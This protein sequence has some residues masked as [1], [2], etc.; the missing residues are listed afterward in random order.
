[1]VKAGNH[2]ELLRAGRWFRGLPEALQDQLSA[3]G[4]V[5]KLSPEQRIFSRGDAPSGLFAVLEGRVRVTATVDDGKEALLTVVEPP[6]WFGEIAVFDALPRTHDAVAEGE[7]AVLQV[8]QAALD[9]ILGKEPRYWRD[10]ALLMA[11]KLRLLFVVF[12]EAAVL[13]A[14]LRLAR[15]LVTMAEGYGEWHDR[16]SRVVAVKQGEL[17]AMLAISRQTANQILRRLEAEGVI[18]LTY[19]EIE[20]IDHAALRTAAGM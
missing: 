4:V 1:V 6:A 9:A 16:K 19:G 5:R 3:A 12:E 20:I 13:P 17:A 18:R 11:H 14:A 10:L 7:A 8:P 15:R 2:K